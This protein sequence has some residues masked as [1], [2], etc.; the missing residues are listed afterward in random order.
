MRFALFVGLVG[1]LSTMLA[2]VPASARDLRSSDIHPRDYPTVRAVAYMDE[3]L[4]QQSK[5]R[6]RVASLG[7]DSHSSE[8]FTIAQVRNGTLD[9]ARVSLGALNG[10][11]PATVLPGLPY[12]FKSITHARHVLDGPIGDEILDSL[13]AHGLIGLAFYD[14]GPRHFYASRPIRQPADLRGLR[15]RVQMSDS[16]GRILQAL[17]A[18]PVATP[19]DRLGLVVQSGVVD[20]TEGNLPTYL[21]SGQHQVTRYFSATGHAMTPSVLIFSKRIW[22]TLP[23]ADR[24]LIRR[25]ARSS[26]PTMRRLWDARLRA[27]RAAI[28]GTNVHIVD[29][30]DCRAFADAL[31]PLYPLVVRD[32]RLASLISQIQAGE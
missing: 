5:G 30:V 25:A 10:M 20:A 12:L 23:A 22:D 27:D 16:W 6:H 2:I 9:M 26:V 17:G 19:A 24:D 3:L 31:Q 4:R 14:G 13:E 1:T 28:D 8:G 29:N 21:S 32:A 7:H 11:A 15:V 18:E